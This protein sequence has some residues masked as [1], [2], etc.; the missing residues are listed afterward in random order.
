VAVRSAASW[1]VFR[2]NGIC[3]P[4]IKFLYQGGEVLLLGLAFWDKQAK[5]MRF[6]DRKSVRDQY[7]GEH[8]D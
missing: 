1:R 4:P 3:E 8:L 5:G 7:R 6:Y 2:S